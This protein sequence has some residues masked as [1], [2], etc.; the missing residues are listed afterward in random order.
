LSPLLDRF[1]AWFFSFFTPR[2][3]FSHKFDTSRR[4]KQFEALLRCCGAMSRTSKA[5]QVIE[6]EQWLAL[7]PVI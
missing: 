6:F 2:N 3:N 1:E 7:V 4:K 5:A